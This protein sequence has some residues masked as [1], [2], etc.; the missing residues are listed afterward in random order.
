[1]RSPEGGAP[2]QALL[3]EHDPASKVGSASRQGHQAM[4]VLAQH[5][6]GVHMEVAGLLQPAGFGPLPLMLEFA[7]SLQPTGLAQY[8]DGV[9]MEVAGLLQPA[10]FGPCR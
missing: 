10:G 9:Q 6:D 1:M 8:H 2:R 5:H 4:Q 7:G 3:D